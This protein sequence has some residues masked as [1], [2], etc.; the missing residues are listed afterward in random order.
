MIELESLT[1]ITRNDFEEK[2]KNMNINSICLCG[3]MR[4]EMEMRSIGYLIEN[5]YGIAA[6]IPFSDPM[7]MI[8]I[9]EDNLDRSHRTKIERS[10]AVLII[11]IDG[12]MGTSTR[13]EIAYAYSIHKPVIYL[14][15][16][17]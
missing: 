15:N 9:N 12:Y 5:K 10:D 17:I 16:Y 2:I 7:H 11:D 6:F 14:S 13:K 8:E 1:K 4:Y 3:S